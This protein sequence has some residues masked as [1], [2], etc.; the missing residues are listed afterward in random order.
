MART[1]LLIEPDVDELGA[2]AS[3]LRAHGLEVAISDGLDS[4]AERAR[5]SRVD[6]LLVS[7]LLAKSEGFVDR[8][9]SFPDL[10]STPRFVLV[11]GVAEPNSAEISRSDVEGIAKRVYSLT[12][13]VP[14]AAMRIKKRSR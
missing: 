11:D 14:V 9:R 2:L 4:A 7:G 10:A 13:S 1:V 8:M 5:S 6:L 12:R 3:K